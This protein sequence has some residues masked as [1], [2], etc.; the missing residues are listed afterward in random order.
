[1]TIQHKLVLVFL[2][3]GTMI[4]SFYTLQKCFFEISSGL[5]LLYSARV[6]LEQCIS[7]RKSQLFTGTKST[8]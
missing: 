5:F 3:V 4:M 8:Q 1:M 7:N 6:A 2:K